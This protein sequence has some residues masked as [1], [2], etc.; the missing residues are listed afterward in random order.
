MIYVESH[1]GRY[2]LLIDSVLPSFRERWSKKMILECVMFVDFW[3]SRRD[4]S[5]SNDMLG[6]RYLL[7][8]YCH[9]GR[10]LLLV[11][12]VWAVSL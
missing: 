2:L 3:R 7:S 9:L 6:S 12:I 4:S 1:V 11:N 10:D 5:L 8:I